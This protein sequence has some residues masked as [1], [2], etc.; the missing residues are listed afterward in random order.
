MNNCNISD[1]SD[2]LDSEYNGDEDF[3][4]VTESNEMNKVEETVE[5]DETVEVAEATNEPAPFTV[6]WFDNTIQANTAQMQANYDAYRQLEGIVAGL[7]QMKAL[8]QK[9]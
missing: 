6:E 9:G 8:A 5:V 4:N 3:I 1:C 7:H 2:C